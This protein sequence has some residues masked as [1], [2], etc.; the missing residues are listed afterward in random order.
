MEKNSLGNAEIVNSETIA[1]SNI[2]DY[3]KEEQSLINV[4][5][6]KRFLQARHI[7]TSGMCPTTWNVSM[8]LVVIQYGTELGF[9][10]VQC[11]AGNFLY[12]MPGK[13]TVSL[14]GIGLATLLRLHGHSFRV[15]RDYEPIIKTNN[16]AKLWL[17]GEA[18]ANDAG[19]PVYVMDGNKS[20]MITTIIGKRKDEEGD[21]IVQ[22]TDKE[23]FS[24]YPK[25]L[26]ENVQKYPRYHLYWK[27]VALLAKQMCPEILCGMPL[28]D[29]IATM[30][31]AHGANIALSEEG[32]YTITEK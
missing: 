27:C 8:L 7:K 2:S 13:A 26:P 22:M 11:V 17:Y 31:A 20:R 25:G 23:L 24:L 28:T 16:P 32:S 10:P 21:F 3:T 18:I 6:E 30:E 12:M 29:D 5:G 1:A 15:L 19:D 9:T 4:V 14:Q